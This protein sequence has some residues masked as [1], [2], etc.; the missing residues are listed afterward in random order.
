MP[1]RPLRPPNSLQSCQVCIL[2]REMT[3]DIEHH[4]S[5]ILQY[6]LLLLHNGYLWLSA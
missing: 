6:S 1:R 4:I 2:F 3:R 5:K